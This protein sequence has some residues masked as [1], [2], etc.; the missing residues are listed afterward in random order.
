M[1][2]VLDQTLEQ[3]Q[4][5]FLGLSIAADQ[6]DP[7]QTFPREEAEGDPYALDLGADVWGFF[8]PFFIIALYL[9]YFLGIYVS[10][11]IQYLYVFISLSF[12]CLCFFNLALCS[13]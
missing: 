8:I 10:I 1:Y 3:A 13:F 2:W 5:F 7:F 6:L 12:A 9:Q 4:G 11:C